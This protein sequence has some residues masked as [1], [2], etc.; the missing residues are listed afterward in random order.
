VKGD[1]WGSALF[2]WRGKQDIAHGIHCINPWYIIGLTMAYS[3]FA[4][5]AFTALFVVLFSKLGIL[6]DEEDGAQC[7]LE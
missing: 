6:D 1:G 5:M 7:A 2:E 4:E 3:G